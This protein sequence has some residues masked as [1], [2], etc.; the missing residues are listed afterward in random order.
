[1]NLLKIPLEIIRAIIVRIIS[2]DNYTNNSYAEI[3]ERSLNIYILT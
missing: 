2:L 1:M 3:Y